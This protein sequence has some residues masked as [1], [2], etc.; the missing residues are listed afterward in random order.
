VAKHNEMDPFNEARQ[1]YEA[2]QRKMQ[3]TTVEVTVG[4]TATVKLD[5]HKQ[6]LAI[7]FTPV[8][9]VCLDVFSHLL[10]HAINEAGSKV[11]EAMQS[12]VKDALTPGPEPVPETLQ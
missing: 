4:G 1:Q 11:D 5:G 2:L 12:A 3:E 7:E 6:V 9:D 8:G 10:V